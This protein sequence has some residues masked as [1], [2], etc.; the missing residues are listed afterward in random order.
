MLFL[1]FF[2]PLNPGTYT[3]AESLTTSGK[4]IIVLVNAK[5][6]PSVQSGGVCK[7]DFRDM[8]YVS[9]QKQ[10]TRFDQSLIPKFEK[11]GMSNRFAPRTERNFHAICPRVFETSFP[12]RRMA[13]HGEVRFEPVA[14]DIM[15]V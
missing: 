12:L 11:T 14:G 4:A 7:A 9:T 2:L 15:R 3:T 5:Q 6:P 10:S 8:D 13:K 1:F